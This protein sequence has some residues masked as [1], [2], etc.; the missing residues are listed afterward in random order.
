MPL[1]VKNGSGEA[2]SVGKKETLLQSECV[3][4]SLGET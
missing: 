3:V 1:P 2:V 4:V